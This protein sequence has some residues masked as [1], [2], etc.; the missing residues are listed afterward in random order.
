MLLTLCEVEQLELLSGVALAGTVCLM[1]MLLGAF[2]W[3]LVS[4]K[5]EKRTAA[6]EAAAQPYGFPVG[7]IGGCGHLTDSWTGGLIGA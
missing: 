7:L 2:V 5:L 1:P 3:I 4:E 6:V